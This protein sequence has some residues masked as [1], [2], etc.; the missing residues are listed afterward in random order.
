MLEKIQI[1]EEFAATDQIEVN[2]KNLIMNIRLSLPEKESSEMLM[3]F[4]ISSTDEKSSSPPPP[5]FNDHHDA[6][7]VF[8]PVPFSSTYTAYFALIIATNR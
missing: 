4:L 8:S 1:T 5:T 2:L 6:V 7:Y 3:S